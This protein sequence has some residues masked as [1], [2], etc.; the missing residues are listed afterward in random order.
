[1]AQISGESKRR[2]FMFFDTTMIVKWIERKEKEKKRKINKKKE[3]IKKKKNQRQKF[4]LNFLSKT[5]CFTKIN[6]KI[7]LG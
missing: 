6:R 5:N 2:N 3:Q 1:M 7:Q 4:E